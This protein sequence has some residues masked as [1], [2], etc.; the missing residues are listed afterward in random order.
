[1]PRPYRVYTLET[2]SPSATLFAVDGPLISFEVRSAEEA[3]ER[4]LNL[5]FNRQR[6][7]IISVFGDEARGRFIIVAESIGRE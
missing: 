5:V 3:L 4:A 1:M 6:E 2:R 7:K